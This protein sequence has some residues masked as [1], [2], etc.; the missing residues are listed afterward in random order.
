MADY[1]AR[2][3]EEMRRPPLHRWLR[4]EAVRAD[5]TEV[6][7]RLPFRPEFAGGVDPVFVHG[8]IIA[9]LCDLTSHAAAACAAGRP[10][11]TVTLATDYLRAAPGV[12]LRAVGILR[13]LGRSL[14]RVDVEI[15]AAD[16][17]IALSR[18]TFAIP[19]ER[20]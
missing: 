11:P 4:P 16:R 9:T 3:Q 15:F 7:V 20:P 17:L 2:L 10:V 5:G 14:A 8:G 12:D 6:E 18:T 19:E 13:R 1:F